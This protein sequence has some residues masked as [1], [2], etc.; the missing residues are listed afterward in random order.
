MIDKL[1]NQKHLVTPV[2]AV[3]KTPEINMQEE[4]QEE[5]LEPA[6]RKP[7]KVNMEKIVQGMNDFLKPSNTHL[8][9]EF[10][11]ELEEYYVTMV[12]DVTQE[13]IREIPSKKLLDMYAA[14]TEYLGILVDKK[15]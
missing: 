13:V 9:F 1:G 6:V 14:M 15:I 4:K 2:S 5:K 7:E 12:D 11:D 8:K 10:H 3:Q